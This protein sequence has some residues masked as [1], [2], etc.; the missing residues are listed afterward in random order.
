MQWYILVKGAKNMYVAPI[1]MVHLRTPLL[2][3]GTVLMYTNRGESHPG[4][5]HSNS[6]QYNYGTHNC[7]RNSSSDTQSGEQ[8]LHC[9]YFIY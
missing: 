7:T 4:I 8:S 6:R 2:A 9:Y 3:P 1:R 5:V